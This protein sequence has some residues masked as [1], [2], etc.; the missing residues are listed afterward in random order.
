[1]YPARTSSAKATRMQDSLSTSAAASTAAALRL[2]LSATLFAAMAIM[3]KLVS[4]RVPGSEVALIRF[5][6]GV[7]AV[8][9]GWAARRIVIR[10]RRWAWLLA[11]GLFGGTAVLA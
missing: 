6:G 4:R 5:A 3:A 2:T 7:I 1:M 11:R 10:P 9:A 8:A